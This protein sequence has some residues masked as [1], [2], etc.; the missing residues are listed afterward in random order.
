MAI[1]FDDYSVILKDELNARARKN[2]RYSMRAFSR[3]LGV[4][5][6]R[7]SRILSG[8]AAPSRATALKIGRNLGYKDAKL[9]WYCALV[10]ARHG[11]SPESR[12]AAESILRRY[13]NGV[14]TKAVTAKQTLDWNWHH[15]AIRRLTQV[16]GFRSDYSWIAS[17]LG[18]SWRQT[19]R[20]IEEL[21]RVGALA[22][23]EG[24]LELRD[25]YSVYFNGNKT[26]VREKMEA[27]LYAKKLPSI[28]SP[29]RDRSHHARHYFAISLSQM[30]EIKRLIKSFEDQVDDL[31]YKAKDPEDL[32]CL[33]IDLW[34]LIDKPKES[35]DSI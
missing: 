23:I 35:P 3:D 1:Y 9:D 10:E 33:S 17:K 8:K 26:A 29:T 31:T 24:R 21:V 28:L 16:A 20:A 22:V 12:R 2:P 5:S 30:D 6:A 13:A 34:S 7:L 4:S 32:V 14:A 19:K 11:R 18:M 27:D 15:F 25:N